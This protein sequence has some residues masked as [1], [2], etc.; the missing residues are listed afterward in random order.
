MA[1]PRPSEIRIGPY[2]I[3]ASVSESHE[4]SSEVTQY[5]VEQGGAVTDNIRPK[6]IVVTIE[7]I[8]SDT[9]IGGVAAL[10]HVGARGDGK[11][12][13]SSE[14]LA[15]LEAIRLARD[16]V[17]ITTTLRT[18]DNMVMTSLSV[19]RDAATGA[20]LRFSA[21]FQ[22]IIVVTN[23]RSTV[24][25]TPVRAQPKRTAT[26]S[27][28]SKKDKGNVQ[29]PDTKYVN[30]RV[31]PDDGTWFD[32]DAPNP[33]LGPG[34]KGR[35]R[36]GAQP[37]ASGDKWEFHRGPFVKTDEQEAADHIDLVKVDPVTKKPIVNPGW[38]IILP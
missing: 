32:E 15:A 11:T 20:A 23:S 14:A 13:P 4:F 8:V 26:P 29:K 2:V 10:R 6:P 28:A 18:F 9:P 30:R 34:G 16:P 5:P 3:D 1:E 19:P 35:W 36:Y 17:T 37:P 12:T 27:A 24:R 38:Q 7:G 25:V 33:A 21:T 22:Q 31:M